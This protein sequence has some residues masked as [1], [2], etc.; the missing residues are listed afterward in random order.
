MAGKKV[1]NI[2][3]KKGYGYHITK[4]GD[5]MEMSMDEMRKMRGKKSKK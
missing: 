1:G 5:V 4:K 3:R 2:T